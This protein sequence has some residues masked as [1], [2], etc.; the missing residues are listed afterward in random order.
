MANRPGG[1]QKRVGSGSVSARRRGSSI[2]SSTHN[3]FSRPTSSYGGSR[4]RSTR[5]PKMSFLGMII[6]VVVV[7]LFFRFINNGD[8]FIDSVNQESSVNAGAPDAFPVNRSVAPEAREKYT[9]IVGRGDD[10]VTLLVYMIGTD[11]ESRSG[12]ATADINEIVHG[13]ISDQVN[14]ILQTGGTKAWQ[15]SVISSDT[16]QRYQLTEE[17]LIELDD[18]LGQV[19]MVEP[20]TL[21]DFIQF[22]KA[23]YPADRY[24]LILWDHG[25]GSLSGYGYDE[26]FPGDTMTLDEIQSALE[27][28]GVQFDFIGFDACLMATF[29]TALVLEPYADYMI[30]SEELEPGIGWY[31]T[32]WITMLSENTSVETIDLGKKI[33]DDYI[34]TV[35]EHNSR[36]QATLSLVDLAELS[37]TVPEAFSGFAVSTNRLIEQQ[38]YQVISDARSGAKEFA[39]SSQINQIDLVHFSRNI[40]TE[41]ANTFADVLEDL[42]K[43]NRTTSNVTQANGLSIYFPY[44]NLSK[45]GDVIETYDDIGMEDSYT[46]CIRSFASVIAGGQIVADQNGSGNLIN[47]LLGQVISGGEG[48]FTESIISGLISDYFGAGDFSAITGVVESLWLDKALMEK[49]AVYYSQNQLSAADFEITEKDGQQVIEMPEDK[50]ALVQE[51]E[52]NVFIDDGEGFIDL[53]L[54]NVYEWN[55]DGDLIMAYDGTWLTLNGQLVSYYMI[56]SEYDGDD[57]YIKGRVPA[58]LNDVPVNIILAFDQDDPYGTVLGAQIVYDNDLETATEAKGL[59]DIV[60]GDSIDFVCDYYTYDGTYQASYYLGDAYI[61]TGDWYIEN[62]ELTNTHYQMSYKITDIYNNHYWTETISD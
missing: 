15:N 14:I 6:L 37:G 61:A 7:F 16:N 32:D 50:W 34:K 39:A 49:S 25:G 20:D 31:Y 23:H 54:D 28:G 62:L 2:S 36:T 51:L 46:D 38:D 52:M 44:D 41:A 60:A 9:D 53:G 35:Y 17:G 40:G 24:Q 18:H 59:I 10:E 42:V 45:L 58:F 11:L 47:T 12:M 13:H 56:S 19:S 27:M 57:Y 26:L 43:Y 48:N 5:T 30:A 3:S 21:A 4:S 1:R 55:D 29:E 22:G 8:G 33:I